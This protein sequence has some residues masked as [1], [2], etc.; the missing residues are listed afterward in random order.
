MTHTERK[1]VELYAADPTLLVWEPNPD[2]RFINLK[3]APCPLL[4]TT[5]DGLALCT[6]HSRRPYNCRRW[7]C[8]RPDPA[9]EPLREDNTRF[10]FDCLTERLKDPRVNNAYK[11][12][13]KEAQPWALQN[14]WPEE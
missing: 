14:G 5:I 7:G 4:A 8:F 12:M 9:T 1:I 2:P 3:A 11:A 6:I 10:G 13:Q